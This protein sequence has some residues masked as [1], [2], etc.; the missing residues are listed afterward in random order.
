[1][2]CA[3]V[4]VIPVT[5]GIACVVEGSSEADSV[6]FV[7]VLQQH[8]ALGRQGAV[9]A[10][11][12]MCLV[13]QLLWWALCHYKLEHPLCL[14]VLDGAVVAKQVFTEQWGHQKVEPQHRN[15]H[16]VPS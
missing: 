13:A 1:M 2:A 10:V 9:V 15:M 14:L 4:T 7:A 12:A 5:T 11:A 16:S 3:R 6:H 8:A